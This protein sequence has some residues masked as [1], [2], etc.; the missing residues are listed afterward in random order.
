M[1]RAVRTTIT[2]KDFMPRQ[3]WNWPKNGHGGLIPPAK[4]YVHTFELNAESLKILNLTELDSIHW[5]AELVYNR[6][7]NIQDKE[8]VQRYWMA[9]K[10]SPAT[11]NFG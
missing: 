11:M 2:E 6:K 8:V 9:W 3:A 4:S 5:I 7:L 10:I 1:G